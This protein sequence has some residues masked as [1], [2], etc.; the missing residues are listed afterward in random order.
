MKEIFEHLAKINA[1]EPRQDLYDQI[2]DKVKTRN[3]I[4]LVWVKAVAC[5][6]LLLIGSEFYLTLSP[7]FTENKDI[8]KEILTTHNLLYHE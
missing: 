3:T 4:P 1:V 5:F 8:T 7:N 6:L 2:M